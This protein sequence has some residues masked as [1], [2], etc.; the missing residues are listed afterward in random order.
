MRRV[1]SVFTSC[2]SGVIY[3]LLIALSISPIAARSRRTFFLP[4]DG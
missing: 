4:R 3:A 2:L 1:A